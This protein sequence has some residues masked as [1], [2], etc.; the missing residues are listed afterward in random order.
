MTTRRER[1]REATIDE[2]KMIAW[3]QI[4]ENGV[5]LLSL[6]AIAREMGI[7]V[8]GL[9]HYYPNRDALVTAL[10]IDA[11]ESFSAALE[12]A[13]D[14]YET[15]DHVGRFRAIAK[16]YFYWGTT[17]PQ[18]YIFLFGTP[19]P[20]YQFT[21]EVNPAGQRCF[22]V[23]QG[24]IGEAYIAGKLGSEIASIALP[25]TLK[26]LYEPLKFFST[27]YAPTVTLL[28]LSAW[29]TI[30]GITSLWLYGYFSSFPDEQMETYVDLEIEK[31]IRIL[32]L[33]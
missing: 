19:V 25:D 31:M 10:L 8:P 17:N 24:V 12:Y 13:R 4:N 20:G 5:A 18:K 14:K 26:P 11:F 3:K 30:H 28:A 27:P 9:Y 16:T 32:G 15:N 1:L 2:I 7:T 21:P 23:L 29:A 22:F 6:R 33:E